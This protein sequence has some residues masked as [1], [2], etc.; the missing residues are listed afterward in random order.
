V[1]RDALKDAVATDRMGNDPEFA[2]YVNQFLGHRLMS[3]MSR[4]RSNDE[5][6][7]FRRHFIIG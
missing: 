6:V 1:V 5:E 2:A 7:S 4:E 3:S